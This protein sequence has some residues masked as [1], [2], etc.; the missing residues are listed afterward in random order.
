MKV[1]L[2]AI[3]NP[4]IN[5]IIATQVFT[6]NP[7]HPKQLAAVHVKITPGIGIHLVGMADVAVKESLLRVCTA[8][9]SLGYTIPGK[10]VEI[11]VIN[12]SRHSPMYDLPIAI[13]IMNEAGFTDIPGQILSDFIIAG[14]LGL[15]GSV[16]TLPTGA[17]AIA[18]ENA[19][20]RNIKSILPAWSAI[21]GARFL[22]GTTAVI[23]HLNEIRDIIYSPMDHL[24]WH[25]K[26]F[27][28][29]AKMR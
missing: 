8:L 7:E 17:G 9:T 26:E 5:I 1:P 2:R 18:V 24:V 19:I 14:E 29:F 23:Y 21:E 22:E 28:E 6:I 4:K 10:K 13:G 3:I 12:G 11:S 27:A 15:D 16:R 20:A 25:C